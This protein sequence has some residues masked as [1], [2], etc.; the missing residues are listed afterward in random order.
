MAS[1]GSGSPVIEVPRKVIDRVRAHYPD[2]PRG[3]IRK[4]FRAVVQKYGRPGAVA[5][6]VKWYIRYGM[7][8]GG[9][10]KNTPSPAQPRQD[11]AKKVHTRLQLSLMRKCPTCS[12]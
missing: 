1:A 7:E 5:R 8:D 12:H 11:K 9:R 4:R 6:V 10:H 2:A 3:Q